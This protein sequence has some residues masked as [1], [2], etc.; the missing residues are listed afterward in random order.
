MAGG[1]STDRDIGELLSVRAVSGGVAPQSL[2]GSTVVS[3]GAVDR[4]T[5]NDPQSCVLHVAGGVVTGAPTSATVEAILRHAPDNGS[6]SPGSWANYAS[7]T[8]DVTSGAAEASVNVDLSGANRW[9]DTT[10]TPAFTGGTS[11]T[12]PAQATVVFGGGQEL[13]ATA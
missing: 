5:L 13:P 8:I 6:G 2:S 1:I 12:A 11:P 10:L 7:A 3:G 4:Y 9:I